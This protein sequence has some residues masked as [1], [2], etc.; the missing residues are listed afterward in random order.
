M[1]IDIF[2]LEPT[3]VSRDLRGKIVLFYGE[4]KSGKTTTAVKFPNS[5][6]LAFEKGYNALNNVM[7]QPVNKWTEF[8]QILKQLKDPKA[9]QKFSTIIVDT[10]DI[11]W[12]LAE[13]YVCQREGVEKVGDI[14]FG[15]GYKMVES[16]VDESLRSIPLMD[17]GLVMISH[18]EDKDFKDETGES[19]NKIVPT[20][21]KKAR[22]IVLRMADIIGYSRT[23]QDEDGN[24]KV[25]LY[26]RG[27]PR[28]EAGSRWRHTP[29]VITFTYDNLTEAIA[30]AIELQ[31]KEDGVESVKEH[32]NVYKET[33]I[34]NFEEV[35]TEV[36]E[37]CKEL[38]SKDD[39]ASKITKIV[40]LHLGKGKK[41]SQATEDQVDIVV[42]VLDDLKELSKETE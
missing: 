26:M 20:L 15:G 34:Y 24:T 12:D 1:A 5:L 30:K 38:M 21:S 8:K 37:L 4:P 39:Y 3:V 11:M 29:E 13:K 6:L 9:Q 28:F 18:A 35:I 7:A 17:Y 31:D 2:N 32:V 36:T 41:V 40:E 10:A 23:V 19:F 42:L 27:T 16:E 33:S 22:K 25:N 14:P